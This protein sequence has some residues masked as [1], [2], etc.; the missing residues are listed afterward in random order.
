MTIKGPYRQLETHV[1]IGPLHK[2]SPTNE[3]P[4]FRQRAH[5]DKRPTDKEPL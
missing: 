3:M 1:D 5:T 2:W 4:L